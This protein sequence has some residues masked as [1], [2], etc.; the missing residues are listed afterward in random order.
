MMSSLKKTL[1]ITSSMKTSSEVPLKNLPL[2]CNNEIKRKVNQTHRIEK[3]R[4]PGTHKLSYTTYCQL[5][6]AAT[7]S[8]YFVF[9][10]SLLV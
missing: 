9:K 6:D 7:F 2:C 1:N 8:L 4:L 5:G 3:L 10:R